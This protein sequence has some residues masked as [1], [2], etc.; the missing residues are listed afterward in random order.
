HFFPMVPLCWALRSAGHEV[1]AALPGKFTAVAESAG[2][3]S[4]QI[5][6]SDHFYNRDSQANHQTTP[7]W[8]ANADGSHH[9]RVTQAVIEHVLDTYMPISYSNAEAMVKLADQWRPDLVLHTPW[10]Y[11]GPLVATMLGIPRV[12]HS[13][14]VALPRELE[15][16]EAQAIEPLLQKWGIQ[17]G[18]QEAKHHIDICPPSLQYDEVPTMTRHMQYIP[19]NG[20][21]PL[22]P[23]LLEAPKRKRVCVSIGSVPIEN[24]H[25]HLLESVI[26]AL[27][28][29]DVEG[30]VLTGGVQVNL[31]HQPANVKLIKNNIPLSYVLPSCDFVIHH[32]GSGSTMTSSVLGLPQLAIPQ[33]CDQFRHAERTAEAKVG[34]TLTNKTP[35]PDEVYQAATQLISDEVYRTNA[36]KMRIENLQQPK[37]EHFVS[38]LESLT[39]R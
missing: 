34:I 3:T 2:I 11:T 14:G 19:F 10:D 5:S 22:E 35:H 24:G 37:P 26:I 1:M 6:S 17:G 15:A 32:G 27:S 25:A 39:Q 4:T 7:Q 38:L 9:G 31:E 13:W 8:G 28:R 21:S 12:S 18:L 20:S 16:L 23:W 30:V 36:R 29:M 33:M